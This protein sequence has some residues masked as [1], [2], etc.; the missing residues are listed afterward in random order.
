M[1]V[2]GREVGQAIHIGPDIRI[3]VTEISNGRVKIGIEA[4][5]E[6]DIWREELE[7]KNEEGGDDVGD[8]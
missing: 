4:P 7:S 1:L 2:L 6:I 3:V 8:H 5:R